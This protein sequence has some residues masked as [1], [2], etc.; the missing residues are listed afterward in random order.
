MVKGS[1]R[2][3]DSSYPV[4]E[5]SGTAVTNVGIMAMGCPYLLKPS[6]KSFTNCWVMADNL[7]SE[8]SNCFPIFV[9]TSRIS[10]R[11]IFCGI[12]GIWERDGVRQEPRRMRVA[13]AR[14]PGD[15]KITPHVRWPYIHPKLFVICFRRWSKCSLSLF[16]GHE[17]YSDVSNISSNF[18]YLNY[19][20][21][22]YC[23]VLTSRLPICSVFHV[24]PH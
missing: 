5:P 17:I 10:F 2:L 9:R 11:A 3:L 22:Q 18:E 6:W 7:S 1:T 20:Q 24:A 13:L 14:P 21:H 15:V 4:S 23:P 12:G 19:Y 8:I 16:Q